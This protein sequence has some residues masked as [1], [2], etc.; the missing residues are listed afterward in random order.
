[1]RIKKKNALK[2]ILIKRNSSKIQEKKH[3]CT[4]HFENVQV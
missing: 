4:M 2:T 1:M 3:C